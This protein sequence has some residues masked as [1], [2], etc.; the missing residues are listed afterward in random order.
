LPRAWGYILVLAATLA[1]AA[2]LLL[3]MPETVEFADEQPAPVSKPPQRRPPK[4]RATP[5]PAAPKAA[6]PKPPEK[7]FPFRDTTNDS[8]VLAPPPKG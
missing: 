4:P 7:P 6:V 5:K 1:G 8:K 2:A 3:P